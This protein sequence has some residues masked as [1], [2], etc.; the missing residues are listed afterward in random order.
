[1]AICDELHRPFPDCA[2]KSIHTKL[3]SQTRRLFAAPRQHF[4]LNLH[5]ICARIWR[6]EGEEQSCGFG[7]Q[8]KGIEGYADICEESGDHFG[9]VEEWTVDG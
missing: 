7:A 3:Y 4:G 5:A 9:C 8:R 1:M 6:Y 2:F